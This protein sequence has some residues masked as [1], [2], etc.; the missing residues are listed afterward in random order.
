[1]VPADPAVWQAEL[2]L[3]TENLY[4]LFTCSSLLSPCELALM[5]CIARAPVASAPVRFSQWRM[6]QESREGEK[7]YL[8]LLCPPCLAW[9]GNGCV[10]LLLLLVL[11]SPKAIALLC[12]C[13]GSPLPLPG[14]G[15][16]PLS[17]L[18]VPGHLAILCS[19]LK[20]AHSFV[21]IRYPC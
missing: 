2:V 21:G 13:T 18:Q 4:P 10:P 20:Y 16:Q 14:P 8:L 6:Y 11:S 12:V 3:F 1:M 17:L 5:S 7:K 15:R 9:F 19:S